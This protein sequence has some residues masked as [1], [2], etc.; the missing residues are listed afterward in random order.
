MEDGLR[1]GNKLRATHVDWT[2]AK[3]KG[4]LAAQTLNS[5]V[6]DAIEFGSK[7]LRLPQF[8]RNEG[9]V[10]FLRMLDRLFDISNL[11][12]PSANNFKAP[13]RM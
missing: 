7:D 5:T 2:K 8:A 1:L 4:N 6:P 11:R 9:T 13:L 12:K 10:R 3:M